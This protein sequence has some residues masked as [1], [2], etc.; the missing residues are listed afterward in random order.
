[1]F[2]FPE[3]MASR[4]PRT[5][6]Y[7]SVHPYK[8]LPATATAKMIC[9]E[10]EQ[11]PKVSS[12]VPAEIVGN[13]SPQVASTSNKA[14]S[15]PKNMAATSVYFATPT[16]DENEQCN[17]VAD[18][19]VKIN[20]INE[21]EEEQAAAFQE[22]ASGMEEENT[23]VQPKIRDADSLDNDFMGLIQ[24]LEEKRLQDKLLMDQLAAFLRAKVGKLNC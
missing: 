23:P 9:N 2:S 8:T 22:L 3:E 6:S 10:Q 1:M 19:E 15:T 11:S 13:I 20:V 14:I 16:K 12:Q 17:Q 18:N 24:Q 7:K 21:G 5:L 4:N